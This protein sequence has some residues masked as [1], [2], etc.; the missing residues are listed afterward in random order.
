MSFEEEFARRVGRVIIIQGQV[1]DFDRK[2]WDEGYINRKDRENEGLGLNIS[3][4]ESFI[5]GDMFGAVWR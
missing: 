1:L 3:G 2:F 4:E 5:G